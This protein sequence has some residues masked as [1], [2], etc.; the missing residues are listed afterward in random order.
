[1]RPYLARLALIAV[2]AALAACGGPS[3]SSLHDQHAGKTTE[4]VRTALGAPENAENLPRADEEAPVRERWFYKKGK[5]LGI[6]DA[7]GAFI[8]V[9]FEGG[10]E[11]KMTEISADEHKKIF[12]DME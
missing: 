7:D 4:Q 12:R 5:A 2:V 3:A 8:A 1:M 9:E 10:K 6:E 11:L